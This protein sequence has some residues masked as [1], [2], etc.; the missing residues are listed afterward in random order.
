MDFENYLILVVK[1]KCNAE[2]VENCVLLLEYYS[3][4]K[5][6]NN[7]FIITLFTADNA[8]NKFNLISIFLN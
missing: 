5:H 2:K 7:V 1:Y 3:T 6:Y 4:I 8:L